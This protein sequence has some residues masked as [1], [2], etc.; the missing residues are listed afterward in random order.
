MSRAEKNETHER[1]GKD[2]DNAVQYE[3]QKLKKLLVIARLI[4]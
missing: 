4:S 1:E 2:N 3:I